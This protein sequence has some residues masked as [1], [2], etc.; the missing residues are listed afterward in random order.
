M[1][2][3][4]ALG[5]LAPKVNCRK[6]GGT[7]PAPTPTV[8]GTP[9]LDPSLQRPQLAGFVPPREACLQVLEQRLGFELRSLR[10]ALG[11][12][13]PVRTKRVFPCPPVT[14]LPKL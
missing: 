12:L 3:A 2:D 10:Q 13:L 5:Y 11:D 1:K 7:H 6:S 4:S 14:H 8:L 9:L